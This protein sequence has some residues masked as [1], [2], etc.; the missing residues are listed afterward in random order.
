MVVHAVLIDVSQAVRNL[1]REMKRYLH[2]YCETIEWAPMIEMTLEDILADNDWVLKH[3][4]HTIDIVLREIGLPP[5]VAKK[6][7]QKFT[8]AITSNIEAALGPIRWTNSYRVKL[9]LV[10]EDTLN[11]EITIADFGS[12]HLICIARDLQKRVIDEMEHGDDLD[13]RFKFLEELD[14]WS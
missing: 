4:D 7:Q 13:E 9:S 1:Q 10:D 8:H 5:E 6:A 11:Y 14:S 3:P 12:R 2:G